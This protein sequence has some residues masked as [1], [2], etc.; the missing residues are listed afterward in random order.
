[1]KN[2]LIFFSLLMTMIVPNDVF[3]EKITD[4]EG[5]QFLVNPVTG[6]EEASIQIF[7]INEGKNTLEF[8]F[9][10]SQLYEMTIVNE[11][12]ETVYQFSEGKS[13]LQAIQHIRLKSGET[14]VW[15]EDLVYSDHKKLIPGKYKV[16]AQLLARTINGEKIG[17]TSSLVDEAEMVIPEKNPVFKN[18]KI[19]KKNN[20]FIVSGKARPM[21]GSLYYLVEDGHH[22][23]IAET[24][25]K[26]EKSYP[27]WQDFSFE[28][29]I[30]KEEKYP[31]QLPLILYLYE[32]DD[33]GAIIYS[34]PK[35]LK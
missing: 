20:G 6:P 11:K 35:V 32:K 24:E 26:I 17:D 4:N 22:E 30:P 23:W 14:K 5:F 9:N 10:N 12:N 16:I 3:G 15:T 29:V 2:I 28:L 21:L 33:K 25:Q 7:L 27:K 19:S 8:E 34:Y 31:R 18:I 1:M 13:F